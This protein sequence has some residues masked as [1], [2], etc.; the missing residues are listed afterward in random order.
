MRRVL[1][2][3]ICCCQKCGHE[4]QK[5]VVEPKQCPACHSY[6]WQEQKKEK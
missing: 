6:D 1:E 4:W 5:R 2:D 3:L